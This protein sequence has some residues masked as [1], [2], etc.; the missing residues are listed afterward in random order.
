MPPTTIILKVNDKN[1][2][3]DKFTQSFVASTMLGMLSTLRGLEKPEELES[4][5]LSICGEEA[6]VTADGVEISMNAFIRDFVRN[7]ARAMVAP[8]RGVEPEINTMVLTLLLP[9]TNRP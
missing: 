4:L 2:E 6:T 3:L 9:L 5:K 8:L 1:I 7:T